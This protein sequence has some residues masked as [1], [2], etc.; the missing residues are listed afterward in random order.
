LHPVLIKIGSFTI[1]S[2]GTMLA[3][4]VLIAIGGIGRIARNEGYD[5]NMVFDLVILAVLG[6]LL[7]ARLAYVLVYDW[8]AFL[9]NPLS[10]FA[11]GSQGIEGMIWYGAFIGGI[12]P[13]GLYIWKKGLSFWNIADMFSPYLA[14]GYA[15]VRI[16][17]FLRGC[18]YGNIT[19]GPLGVVFPYI[20]TFSRHPTQLYSSGLNL[21]LFAFLLWVYKRRSF[22]GQ[23]FIFYLL[24]YGIYRFIIEFFR[25]SL[26]QVGPFT[27]GQ[28]Y[29]AALFAV[30]MVLYYWR[31]R[32]CNSVIYV[33]R[34]R[35]R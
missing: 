10:L 19:A 3:I 11:I 1:Y 9:A 31:Q 22:D 18:C 33:S 17:C 35:S 29:T 25:F 26:I 28:V 30:G 34:K 4:A 16:G 12:I 20:D 24:G 23:V 2:W 13:F 27:L 6:G 7:G 21:L 8:Q 15:L 5:S 14:L 32:Q